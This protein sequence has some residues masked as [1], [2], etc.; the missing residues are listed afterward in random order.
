MIRSISATAWP[1]RFDLLGQVPGLRVPAR[2]S[3]FYF[4]GRTETIANIAHVR[5]IEAPPL[6]PC[7]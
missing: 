7:A 1:R 2:T 6:I 5:A 4:K 3:S